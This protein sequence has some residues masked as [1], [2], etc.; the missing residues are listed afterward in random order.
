[1]T[2]NIKQ[3]KREL[4]QETNYRCGYC[5]RNIT[6]KMYYIEEEATQKTPIFDYTY[7][8]L[9]NVHDRA[10]IEPNSDVEDDFKDYY[11]LI[12]L[13]KQCHWEIDKPKMLNSNELK[14][15]KLY[16][17]VA[18]G[19]FT[20]LEIDCLFQLY[21]SNKNHLSG[22]V[23][24]SVFQRMLEPDGSPFNQNVPGEKKVLYVMSIPRNFLF[25]FDKISK[26]KFVAINPDVTSN[27]HIS[28]TKIG[29]AQLPNHELYLLP[30]GMNFCDKF[31][32]VY[33]EL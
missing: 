4:L 8:K 25:M 15:Q 6:P 17:M 30:D 13:C 24:P 12:A 32:D 11:N 14:R 1:M 27:M 9:F 2:I 33:E 10:H 5:M 22:K 29:K 16:W 19:R 18:S 21:Y 7:K 23:Y 3:I 31:K 28:N 20:R 26:N